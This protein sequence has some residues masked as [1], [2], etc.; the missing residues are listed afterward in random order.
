VMLG[1]IY[2]VKVQAEA[3][4]RTTPEDILKLEVRNSRGDMVP[5]G[6]IVEVQDTFGPQAV[7]HHNIYPSAKINGGAAPGFTSGQ[8]MEL[9]RTMAE[10]SLP[11]NMGFE[12]TDLSYQEDKA[13]GG[14]VVIFMF[15]IIFVYLVLAAQYESWSLPL[16]VCLAV[17]T[18][19]LGSVA[20]I[21]VRGYDNNVYTQIGVVLLIGL[22]T[23]TAILIVEFAKAKREEGMGVAEA[24]V[25]A[26]KLRFR[27]VLMTAVSFIL[28]VLPL[29]LASG[30]GAE[31]RKVI[32][33]SVFSG[34]VVA[35]VVS[36]VTVPMLYFVIQ[37]LSEKLGGRKAPVP[38]DT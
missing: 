25:Y 22:S 18:A 29:L 23:K 27:A 10:E 13:T 24:A 12:W 16:S 11:A 36:V 30:S 8:S 31:S 5:M 7:T 32:G 20:G 4:Y 2:Q 34:M 17:P 21:M 38:A 6:T 37:S 26:T 35:T 1:R 33:T 14:I 28:G 19:L 3:K 9:V 15:S